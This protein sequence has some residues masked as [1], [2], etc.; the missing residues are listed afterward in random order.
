M[1]SKY[2]DNDNSRGLFER[3]SRSM[4]K[5][6]N[7]PIRY[8]EPYPFFVKRA[9]GCKVHDVDNNQYID[10]CMGYGALL[11][12]HA[13][14][15]VI[16]AVREQ[17]ARGSLY[18]MPTEQEVELAELLQ[19]CIPCAEAVRLV[20]TG[21][22]A[23]Y[24]AIR[25]ARAYTRRRKIVRFDG[26]YHGSHDYT[27]ARR[28]MS[29]EERM[30]KAILDGVADNTLVLP[31]NDPDALMDA[32]RR[33]G[34]DVAAVIVEPVM[35]NAGLIP[36]E[37]GYLGRLSSICREYGSLLIF[38]EVV[39][40]F[41]L[42]LGGAEEYYN[43]KPDIATFAKAMANGFA[44][45]C[46]AGR[47]DVMSVLAPEGRLYQGS[48]FAGNP[49]SVTA[50]LATIRYLTRHRSLYS[51][52]ARR[53]GELVSMIDDAIEDNGLTAR[54]NSI[55]SMLQVFFTSRE[56][57]DHATARSS[58]TELF[59]AY[60]RALL[61]QGIFIPPSQFEVCFLSL[62][63]DDTIIRSTGESID[64]A[65]RELREQVEVAGRQ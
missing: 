28:D 17:L 35:A 42:A 9:R 30:D 51:R 56:V 48:T 64:R 1:N 34:D 20:N 10:Y 52:I 16:D 32:M 63:H 57:R 22:E 3:A 26:C 5:G 61:K 24:H 58:N 4:I 33:E 62:A 53:C 25:I 65:F 18:C 11:L 37:D 23:T 50:S 46:I 12:G 54:V 19:R 27:L 44:I 43:I 45:A 55:A 36:P 49:I 60:F 41:R 14:K 31:Y 29:R 2:I 6:V 21:M 38:D 7:S 47:R 8:F 59:K 39:T 15:A 40:G 13:F